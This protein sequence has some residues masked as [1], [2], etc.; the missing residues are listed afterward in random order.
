MAAARKNRARFCLMILKKIREAV[1][2]D[3]IVEILISGEEEST[4]VTPGRH[5]GVP[6]LAAPLRTLLESG[7]ATPT[8]PSTNYEPL[9]VPTLDTA[10]YI[11]TRTP[12]CSLPRWAAGNP[13]TCE[14]NWICGLHGPSL[15]S[16][17]DCKQAHL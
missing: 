6:K 10:A 12:A 17:P 15:V 11:K 9:E 16:N 4:A 14:A 5:G 7:P 3:F 1:G 8:K 13:D 2:K